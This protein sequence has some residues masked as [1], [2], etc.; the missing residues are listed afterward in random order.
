[1]NAVEIKMTSAFSEQVCCEVKIMSHLASFAEYGLWTA[2]TMLC[3]LI[4][5]VSRRSLLLMGDFKID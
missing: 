4:T 5:E 2:K 3:D 1:M